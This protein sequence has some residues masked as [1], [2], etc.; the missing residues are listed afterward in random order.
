MFGITTRMTQF[1]HPS[2]VSYKDIDLSWMIGRVVTEVS[3]SVPELW[4]FSFGPD[5][6]IGVECLWRIVEHGRVGLTSDDHGH[7]FGLPAPVDA[8]A[9]ST[10]VLSGH[11]VT[12]VQLRPFT[13]DLVI[14]FTD[15]L[16][17]EII[18][19]SSGYEAWQ[20]RAAT[21]MSYIAV[22]GGEVSKWKP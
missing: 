22:G 7:Q 11:R 12:A 4:Y 10:D 5:V 14:E 20:L 6:S 21:G 2:A 19:T 9:R 13:A 1:I 17:L 8:V 3:I 15:D 16:R 18:P